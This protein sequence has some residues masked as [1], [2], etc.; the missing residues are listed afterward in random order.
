MSKSF[1]KELVITNYVIIGSL[2]AI[3]IVANLYYGGSSAVWNRTLGL[4]AVLALAVVFKI[5]RIKAKGDN[6]DE[7]LQLIMYRSITIGFYF[8]LSA[9][10]WY[11]TKEMAIYGA[12]STRTAVE[13]LAG[14]VGYLG[15][16]VF[17]N[18]KY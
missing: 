15:S 2:V 18:K 7:R 8:M 10:W 11:Y 5:K 12:V 16:F 9:I 13:M 1:V 14:M 6:L 4:V 17:L 3:S